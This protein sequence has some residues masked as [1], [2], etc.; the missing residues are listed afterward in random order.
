MEIV[1]ISSLSPSSALPANCGF[2]A[3]V[4]L[5][6]PFSSATGQCALLLADPDARQRYQKGQVRVRFTGPSAHQIA[7][8]GIGI[9]DSVQIALVGAKWLTE[10]LVKTPGR[11]VDG[12]LIFDNR[13]H[14]IITRGEK[15][16]KTIDIDEPT[17]PTS[18][19]SSMLPPSTPVARSKP[20]TSF[21][22]YGVAVY[23][24]PAFMKR[25][26]LSE[27][28]APY[29]PVSVSEDDDQDTVA[30]R[31]R[32][33]VSYKNVS[34]WKF[35]TR[36][37][38]PEKEQDGVL[39][40]ADGDGSS[41]TGTAVPA[42]ATRG[43]GSVTEQTHDLEMQDANEPAK[44]AD[45]QIDQ[46]ESEVR[47]SEAIAAAQ[48]ASS[49]IAQVLPAVTAEEDS[50]VTG[51][52]TR[53]AAEPPSVQAPEEGVVD[54]AVQQ[55]AK[56]TNLEDTVSEGVSR[57]LESSVTSRIEVAP[58]LNMPPSGLPRLT[59]LPTESE[60][61]EQMA[62]ARNSDRPVTPTLQ[63]LLTEGLP[64]PSPF[65][66]SAQKMPSPVFSKA[67]GALGVAEQQ[68]AT[69]DAAETATRTSSITETPRNPSPV[70]ESQV[71]HSPKDNMVGA[72]EF[73]QPSKTIQET[74]DPSLPE[75]G[76]QAEA[77]TQKPRIV[78]DTYDGYAEDTAA[79]PSKPSAVALNKAD[80]DTASSS[81][82]SESD[83]A[84]SIYDAEQII[85]LQEE[86]GD[87]GAIEEP[88]WS[89][90]ERKLEQEEAAL[91]QSREDLT[92][93]DSGLVEADDE[94]QVY[95]ADDAVMHDDNS[96]LGEDILAR[97][98]DD[99]AD[100]DDDSDSS[101]YF[102]HA[103]MPASDDESSG[104][105]EVEMMDQSYQP[106]VP[107][108]AMYSH[109][110]GLDGARSLTETRTAL[111]SQATSQTGSV[112]GDE[113][114]AWRDRDAAVETLAQQTQQVQP[115][116]IEPIIQAHAP[117]HAPP[118][119]SSRLD[120]VELLDDSDSEGEGDSNSGPI[121][122]ETMN[123]MS[124]VSLAESLLNNK[125]KDA[126]LEL[127]GP[128]TSRIRSELKRISDK[129]NS[130]STRWTKYNAL[131]AVCQIGSTVVVAAKSGNIF[132]EGVKYR[133]KEDE[134]LVGVCWKIYNELSNEEKYHM[135][136][137][138]DLLE[139]LEEL[140]EKRDYCFDGF[141]DFLKLFKHNYHH[142][143]RGA[144]S[145]RV[146]RQDAPIPPQVEDHEIQ[147]QP[148]VQDKDENDASV[149]QVVQEQ[150]DLASTGPI[151]SVEQHG[152]PGNAAKPSER[153]KVE[154]ENL[155]APEV[156]LEAT[157]FP[158]A[159]PA[160]DE[161]AS[162]E[163]VSSPRSHSIEDPIESQSEADEDESEAD[164]VESEA[165]EDGSE[166]MGVE[167]DSTE[168]VDGHEIDPALLEEEYEIDPALLE[169]SSQSE[170]YEI[171]PALLQEE[172]E[173]NPALL[174][175]SH[176][177][178]P[179]SDHHSLPQA[180]EAMSEA[181]EPAA[182][183]IDDDEESN[184]QSLGEEVTSVMDEL[185]TDVSLPS[186]ID[187][188]DGGQVQETPVK[189]EIQESVEEDPETIAQPEVDNMDA[190]ASPAFDAE[191][192]NT[193]RP[194]DESRPLSSSS[195]RTLSPT[196]A[197][198]A[199]QLTEAII[200][201]AAQDSHVASQVL[202][203]PI[204]ELD[205]SQAEPS[206]TSRLSQFSQSRSSR[207]H[208]RSE[209]IP[210]S[211]DEEATDL[212]A[213]TIND[214]SESSSQEPAAQ[215]SPS[216]DVPK[217]LKESLVQP[218]QELGTAFSQVQKQVRSPSGIQSQ[219]STI[220]ETPLSDDEEETARG[221][222]SQVGI[223]DELLA[224]YAQAVTEPEAIPTPSELPSV[225]STPVSTKKPARPLTLFRGRRS[226]EA[227][228]SIGGEE[229]QTG[230]TEQ[231]TGE[232]EQQTRVSGEQ[233]V[234]DE[235][236]NDVFSQAPVASTDIPKVTEGSVKSDKQVQN[237][238]DTSLDSAPTPAPEIQSQSAQE[239]LAVKETA[240]TTTAPESEATVAVEQPQVTEVQKASSEFQLKP[241]L[242]PFAEV[243]AS[244]FGTP[245]K[246]KTVAPT[247]PQSAPSQT[248]RNALSSRMS[249]VPVIG[250]WFGTPRRIMEVQKSATEH[251]ATTSSTSF[252]Q[253]TPTKA[254]AASSRDRQESISPPP[255]Q[256]YASQGTSTSLS[257]FTPLAGLHQHL[258]QQ[259]SLID[260]VAVCTTATAEPERAR[261]GPKDY[262]TTFR[263]I[264]QPLHEYNT[265]S[266]DTAEGES[267]KD[268][269]IEIFRPFRQSLP[270]ASPGDVVLLCGFVVRSRNHKNY[271]LSTAAS[272]WCVWRYGEPSAALNYEG[273]EEE[274]DRPVWARKGTSQNVGEDG[275]REEVTGPPVEIGDEEREKVAM[276]KKWW[277]TLQK[278]RKAEE[279]EEE[280]DVIM[281]D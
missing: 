74:A 102:D 46:P 271:L 136:Q 158:L 213:E 155:V 223:D 179:S 275:I 166:A 130:Q 279:K 122:P 44:R 273:Q 251:K 17:Q 42:T 14:M 272:G 188:E 260:I 187:E 106:S 167:A 193:Q 184:R 113:T 148:A 98:D 156:D 245:I 3:L 157:A 256:R 261:S 228:S 237:E 109:P 199:V 21:D 180:D 280:P 146:D 194:E 55:P 52:P 217:L 77:T 11:S 176:D 8:S 12:E 249:E 115:R 206:W 111:P 100:D 59:V 105:S 182:L 216:N 141:T 66:T 112:A 64:L 195:F 215:A 192:E 79:S 232:T 183:S 18:P 219:L 60:L 152:I 19:T 278:G 197:A 54:A 267:M 26:R 208:T 257:Y 246:S 65:P 121:V 281:I 134:V 244:L 76:Q 101:G 83:E 29:T 222:Q 119:S 62:R 91:Q 169:N 264:D 205:L 31:K 172:H 107:E 92:A 186:R 224:D 4:T 90:L 202:E 201:S 6:W 262:Y 220:V 129:A 153:S 108:N 32:R 49:I 175:E 51:V 254:P 258:N 9:G 16:L 150:A 234:Q 82:E 123:F 61:L 25:L 15:E 84:S 120:V 27:G 211:A 230:E 227:R 128:A 96:E 71:K 265:A 214:R 144:K 240:P 37:P 209:T 125:E 118:V 139:Y 127:S 126:H 80:D 10:S 241:T 239:P 238:I 268:V 196:P 159:D 24:S 34:E 39:E 248:W 170:G 178:A 78:A 35:D 236:M 75:S 56:A 173:I 270:K 110:F 253:E 57:A 247:G 87:E 200:D 86:S 104:E 88:D 22:A 63:P 162:V 231:Q 72:Q 276:V 89:Y 174:V 266:Q 185:M 36:E 45:R 203:Q 259:S 133:L 145:Q 190:E 20:R 151:S 147:K 229:Q 68:T 95:D 53:S 181:P 135:S 97:S 94:L 33:R 255:L 221:L 204:E 43:A 171:D 160:Q 142:M 161:R 164:E 114:I 163:G 7:T 177:D 40:D 47:S 23:S 274:D 189:S 165:D 154:P 137:P 69:E 252:V 131:R 93:R 269:K 103:V 117:Q 50:P 138:P 235:E 30:S 233:T 132:A 149:P 48:P 41:V 2:K 212:E 242:K 85:A 1:S 116:T 28:A 124:S 140:E 207:A 67:T 263:V 143:P 210:D 81:D 225:P 250:S 226:L 70:P 99:S 191:Q 243:E 13:L 58:S 5:I 168:S 38:S 277:E 198:A 73:A 218:S